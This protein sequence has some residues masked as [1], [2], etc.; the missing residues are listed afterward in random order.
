MSTSIGLKIDNAKQDAVS[1][2]S[3]VSSVSTQQSTIA[4]PEVKP[5]KPRR[6]FDKSYKSRILAAYDACP[7][8]GA[9]SALLRREGLYYSTIPAW[10][11]EIDKNKMNGKSKNTTPRIDHLTRENEQLKK[12]LAQA[13]AIIDL[14]KKV[15]ELFGAHILPR[16]SNEVS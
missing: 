4:D 11:Q 3:E 10:R 15:S 14:Q 2:Q 6:S 16:D 9:R 1:D 13:E 12:K 8:A 5:S 7:N